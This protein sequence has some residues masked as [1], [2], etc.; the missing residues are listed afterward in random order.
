[1]FFAARKD[2]GG[3]KS[4]A[5]PAGNPGEPFLDSMIRGRIT[6]PPNLDGNEDRG[7]LPARS[8][9]MFQPRDHPRKREAVAVPGNHQNIG[10][11]RQWHDGRD[12]QGMIEVPKAPCVIVNEQVANRSR[13]EVIQDASRVSRNSFVLIQDQDEQFAHRFGGDGRLVSA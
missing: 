12:T 6:F 11:I 1:L 2:G 13:Q 4:N 10:P 3:D 8:Q 9:P 5:Q 7:S